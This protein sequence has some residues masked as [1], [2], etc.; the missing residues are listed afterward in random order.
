MIQKPKVLKQ[1]PDGTA[2]VKT[3]SVHGHNQMRCPRCQSMCRLQKEGDKT[4]H[5]CSSCNARFGSRPL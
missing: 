5:I 3:S 2:I 1:N 4:F